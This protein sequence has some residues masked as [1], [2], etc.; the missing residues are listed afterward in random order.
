MI[1]LF[2]KILYNE[3]IRQ[4]VTGAKNVNTLLDAFKNG[5][6]EPA[7]IKEVWRLSVR[8]WQYCYL[9]QCLLYYTLLLNCPGDQHHVYNL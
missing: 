7:Q 4:R 8:G 3:D 1:D 5:K 6:I 9:R 2:I